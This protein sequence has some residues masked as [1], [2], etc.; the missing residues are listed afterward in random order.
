MNNFFENKKILITGGTGTFGKAFINKILQTNIKKVYVFSRDELKQW[1]MRI[2]K[3]DKRLC[4]L[5]GDVRDK[6]RL[7]RA[8]ERIDYVIHAAAQKHVPSC[9]FNPFEAVKTNII[10]AEN[11]INAAID[12]GVKKVLAIS[13]D[14]AVEPV[15]L[16]GMTKGCMEKLFINGN[17]YTG[18]NNTSFSCVR[19][20]NVI[21]SR[22]SVINAWKN[23]VERNISISL[24]DPRMTRFWLTV[25]KA[26]D[27]VIYALMNMNKAEIFVPKLSS[28]NLIN[29]A[30]IFTNNDD[31]KIL[32][33]GRRNGEKL[34]ETLISKYEM[35]NTIKINKDNKEFFVIYQT[36]EDKIN[37][38]TLLEDKHDI[39]NFDYDE[40]TSEN[41][42]QWINIE[43]MRKLL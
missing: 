16:Y 27:F 6:E 10:G 25:N 37:N 3:I 18:E 11:I 9:E 38:E 8:F 34:H 21:G 39:F 33:T 26:V 13:T 15:N 36:L 1:E 29:L 42:D 24:T 4:F 17:N 19:Y 12:R 7:Y 43:E 31:T 22:G 40:Y 32:I 23:A 2:K 20:G 35:S 41:N 30:N 5:L 14:K 28:M